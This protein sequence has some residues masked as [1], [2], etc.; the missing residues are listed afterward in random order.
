MY[1]VYKY[2]DCCFLFFV[3]TSNYSC[4]IHEENY[5]RDYFFLHFK[6]EIFFYS[7]KK[8]NL[9]LEVVNAS[10]HTDRKETIKMFC[11][12]LVPYFGKQLEHALVLTYF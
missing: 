8:T 4:Q 6:N 7:V 11:N 3:I 12:Y 9:S 2:T 5:M 1:Q 10:P